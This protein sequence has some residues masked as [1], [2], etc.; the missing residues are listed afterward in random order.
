[1]CIWLVEDVYGSWEWLVE[2]VWL[3]GDVQGFWNIYRV[4]GTCLGLVEYVYMAC[5][6]CMLVGDVQGFW[7]I[8]RQ[9][10]C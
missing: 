10:F 1:M 2:D 6:R 3:V 5:E 7:N 8:Y 4:S 9:G